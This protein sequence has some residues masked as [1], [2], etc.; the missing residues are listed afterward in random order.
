MSNIA[1][2]ENVCSFLNQNITRSQ[3]VHLLRLIDP[4]VTD[5]MQSDQDL[6]NRL[7]EQKLMILIE[8]KTLLK[9]HV[10][11]TNGHPLKKVI[12]PLARIFQ[13]DTNASAIADVAKTLENV[14]DLNIYNMEAIQ[15]WYVKLK[16]KVNNTVA[17]TKKW[18]L[19]LDGSTVAKLVSIAA[20]LAALARI[21]SKNGEVAPTKSYSDSN[22]SYSCNQVT[23]NCTW[24]IVPD[25]FED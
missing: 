3:I 16:N 22:G 12:L 13:L 14:I 6:C 8:A 10:K 2:E 18:I 25:P 7:T 1:E 21:R 24:T 23:G 9:Q 4:T 15:P 11:E 17:A 19:N 5:A 20:I